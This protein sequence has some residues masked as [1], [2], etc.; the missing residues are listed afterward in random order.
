MDVGDARCADGLGPGLVVAIA[1]SCCRFRRLQVEGIE[2]GTGYA[3]G[4]PEFRDLYTNWSLT[5]WQAQK[6][7]RDAG[8]W[9]WNNFNCMLTKEGGFG[10]SPV[11]LSPCGLAKTE[12]YPRANNTD[13]APVKA[14]GYSE[15]KAG[16]AA[17]HRTA[18]D[19][20]SVLH[21]IP[22][23]L[24][25]T[26]NDNGASFPLPAPLQ[27]I[28]THM[29]V[30]GPVGYLSYGWIGCTSSYEHPPAL[31]YDYGEPAEPICH[32][33]SPGSGV[34]TRKWSKATVTLDCTL[35]LA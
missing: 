12:G 22:L 13:D 15:A 16:C 2:A 18:C 20:T 25:W 17:W 21:K 35:G 19:S 33:T 24:S 1:H 8:G 23:T 29:L 34:F 3:K 26:R 27:D 30:R 32:E 11:D 14:T 7:I 5:T 4:S 28:A 10:G 6:A 31:A 9:T